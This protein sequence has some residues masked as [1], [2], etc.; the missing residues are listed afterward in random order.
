M[1]I[2]VAVALVSFLSVIILPFSFLFLTILTISAPSDHSD[3]PPLIP[4]L[5]SS[6]PSC[7]LSLLPV[8]RVSYYGLFPVMTACIL[9]LCMFVSSLHA[10]GLIP[11]V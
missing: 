1:G 5:L 7:P 10:T 6:Q 11:I 3:V 9:C 8:T 4:L 2:M